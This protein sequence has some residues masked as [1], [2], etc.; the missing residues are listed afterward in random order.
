MGE[1]MEK[2]ITSFKDLQQMYYRILTFYQYFSMSHYDSHILHD[3]YRI[4]YGMDGY[5]LCNFI[6]PTEIYTGT[7]NPHHNATKATWYSFFQNCDGE[8]TYAIISPFAVIELLATI[9]ERKQDKKLV[10]GLLKEFPEIYKILDNILNN[11][12]TEENIAKQPYYFIKQLYDNMVLSNTIETIATEKKPFKIIEELI[13]KNKIKMFDHLIRNSVTKIS[14]NKM[15]SFNKDMTENAIMYLNEKRKRLTDYSLHRKLYN[16]MDVYHYILYENANPFLNKKKIK[17]FIAS[18]GLLTKNSWILLKYGNFLKDIDGIPKTW[19]GRASEVANFV[20]KTQ[21]YFNGRHI[22]ILNFFEEGKALT[23]VIL[24]DLYEIPEIR[25]SVENPKERQLLT[26]KNPQLNPRNKI[27]QAIMRFHND[28]S[29]LLYPEQ[30]EVSNIDKSD[31]LN[32]KI[33]ISALLNWLDSE[34]TRSKE[35]NEIAIEIGEHIN[36]INL[37][38]LKWSI[39]VA[40]IGDT[41]YDI[42]KLYNQ[43]IDT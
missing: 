23:R 12:Q 14:S 38:P 32:E 36:K 13:N 33:D 19:T 1:K 21:Q 40:P 8:T 37:T 39:Y 30:D 34:K 31:I 17:S 43:N 24:R 4:A 5:D 41:A 2:D 35:F 3:G 7:Y 29:R 15:F 10:D 6:F 26:E 25:D 9:R 28:Y 42:L 11:K 27:G 22:D 18:S 20:V 16:T